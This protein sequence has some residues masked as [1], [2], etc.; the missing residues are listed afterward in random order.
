MSIKFKFYA[1][2]LI[3][4][5]VLLVSAYFFVEENKMVFIAVEC[6]LLTSLTLFL[7]LIK[8][9]LAPFEFVDLFN[10]ILSEQEFTTRFSYTGNKELDN[11]MTLFNQMLSQLYDERLRLGDR[12]GMLQQLM[13]ALPLSIIVFDFDKKISQLNPAAEMLLSCNNEEV[14]GKPIH[15][16]QHSL[17]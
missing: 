16:I 5:A 6:V 10:D 9:I 17:V 3:L 4:H 12:K 13:D 15:D 2:T 11:L 14:K 8:K 1:L 7:L